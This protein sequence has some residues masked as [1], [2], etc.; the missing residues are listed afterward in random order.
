[1]ELVPIIALLVLGAVGFCLM[2]AA[3][4]MVGRRGGWQQALRS[5]AHGHW[6]A[7]RRLMFAGALL[8][9][10]FGLGMFVPGVVPWWDYSSPYAGWGLGVT[11]GFGLGFGAGG[12]YWRTLLGGR[13]PL[14]GGDRGP[15]P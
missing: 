8:C 5:D 3:F 2:L 12:L 10:A 6:P 4:V 9:T 11:F 15:Q 13:E 14:R 1:M 7:P